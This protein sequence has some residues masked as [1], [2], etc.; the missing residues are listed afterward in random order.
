MAYELRFA[1]GQVVRFDEEAALSVEQIAALEA[2]RAKLVCIKPDGAE[3][4]LVDIH[5]IQQEVEA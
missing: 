4:V 3:V 2:G 1:D 5:E